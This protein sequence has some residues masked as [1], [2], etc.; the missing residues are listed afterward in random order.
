MTE[1]V[2]TIETRVI[3]Q[4]SRYSDISGRIRV[5]ST[6]SVG[7]GMTISRLNQDDQLQE[8]HKRLRSMPSYMYLSKYE[9]KLEQVAHANLTRYPAGAR[10]QKHAIPLRG[11]SPDEDKLLYDLRKKI[12]KVIDARGCFTSD[13]DEVLERMAEL[14]ELQDEK[15][16]IDHVLE[17]MGE[18][19]SHLSELMRLYYILG[20]SWREVIDIMGISKSVF[21]RW[22][23]AAIEKY[24]ILSGWE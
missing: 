17:I 1:K 2:A 16:K 19:H 13:L 3:D 10:A 23:Q 22:R 18:N 4:L 15:Q 6:Y 24:A 12:Q 14:Q 7:M 9:Q 5:L 8:L 11:S 21:Y 20:K